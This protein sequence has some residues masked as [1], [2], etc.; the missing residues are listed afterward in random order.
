LGDLCFD[1]GRHR[2][3]QIQYMGKIWCSAQLASPETCFDW[4]YHMADA[5]TFLGLCLSAL[6]TT[7]SRISIIL[8][9]IGC[10]RASWPMGSLAD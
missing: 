6:L 9:F 2:K 7:R 3:Y 8:L 10:R 4:Q 1:T 5:D